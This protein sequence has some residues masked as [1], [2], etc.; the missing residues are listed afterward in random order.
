MGSECFVSVK[1]IENFL[2]TENAA[3][4]RDEEKELKYLSTLEEPDVISVIVN[5]S[6]GWKTEPVL[7][8]INLTLKKRELVAVCGPVGAGKSSLLNVLLHDLNLINGEFAM[9]TSKIAYVSQSAWILSGTIKENILFGQPYNESKFN[10]VVKTCSLETD[11]MILPNAENTILG[12]RGVTLSGGQRARVSLARA[13]YYDA[14][15]YLLDDPL[16]AVD[17]KVGRQLFENC[18]KKTLANK[19]ANT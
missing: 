8:D 19:V 7:S 11:F 15:L 12:E 18:I 10:Y 2:N 13:I 5:G 14:D 16:S 9:S 3:G 1:R 6:F 17:T 4:K